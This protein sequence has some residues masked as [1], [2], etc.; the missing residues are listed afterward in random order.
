MKRYLK[1]YIV[2]IV[3]ASA[4][5]ILDQ[6][7]KS[8]IR[9]T[10]HFGEVYRPDLWISQYARL[11]HWK[12]SGAALG[13]FQDHG[14]IFMILAF[15]VGGAILYYY[16]RVTWKEWYLRV[17]MILQLGG[18]M[19]NL[20]DRLTHDMFVTDFISIL[21]LPVFNLADLSIT[22]GVV[23]LFLGLWLREREL[24]KTDQDTVTATE[25]EQDPSLIPDVTP[26]ESP[27][28]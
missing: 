5:A 17:A 9:E 16:P 20:I 18:A 12:N 11:L 26:E 19:G 1:D 13:M 6:V 10:L 4:I 3:L 27:I 21:N 2:L 14:I 7:T 23:I 8:W 24:K 15:A 28:E 25:D 22:T